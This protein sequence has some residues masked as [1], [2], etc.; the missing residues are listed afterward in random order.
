[1]VPEPKRTSDLKRSTLIVLLISWA[2]IGAYVFAEWLFQA[3]KPSYMSG[4]T[5]PAKLSVLIYTIS[6]LSVLAAILCGMILL[7]GMILRKVQAFLADAMVLIPALTLT[8]FALVLFDNF[9]YTIFRFGIVDSTGVFRLIYAAGFL[10]LCAYFFRRL[11][12]QI[13]KISG[14]PQM[15]P[16]RS[17]R[18]LLP[19]L[20]VLSGISFYVPLSYRND[21]DPSVY[22]FSGKGA[23][24][25]I[26]LISAEGIN[27]SHTSVYGYRR[28]TT[29]Y[30]KQLAEES[31]VSENH[32]TNSG[33]TSGSIISM[34]TS[35]TPFNT[36]VLFRPDILFNEDS[37]QHLPGILRSNGYYTAQMSFS[38]FADAYS[39]NLRD[40]FDEANGVMEKKS[41]VQEWINDFLP[42]N[43]SYFIYETGNR[44][45]DRLRHIFFLKTMV[46]AYEQVAGKPGYLNDKGE[47]KRLK[48]LLNRVDQPLFVQLHWMG[49]HG[50]A[51][52][53]ET[54]QFSAGKDI[55]QQSPW[56]DDFYDDGV[57]EFDNF[58]ARLY[59]ELE[60][61]G[62]ADNSVIIITSDHGQQWRTDRRI[63]LLIH[64]PGGEHARR[65]AT[66]TQNIDIAPTLLDVLNISIPR[67]MEGS[68]LLQNV[69]PN[70]IIISASAVE[71]DEA[72]KDLNSELK[73]PPFFQFGWISGIT[74]GS[75]YTIDLNTGIRSVIEI[76]DWKGDCG[77]S[78]D[79]TDVFERMLVYLSSHGFDVS[80]LEDI[81]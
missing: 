40:G 21:Q 48:E 74:C 79:G 76:P 67:W 34:L 54:R 75:G 10:I 64:F 15:V 31:L 29:P 56:D 30:L 8:C 20:L 32:F 77:P 33:S 41:V 14:N 62:M 69:D 22:S 27:A 45:S 3:T 50:P 71:L 7:A 81:K 59:A 24:P 49:T 57:L 38:Y 17:V 80:S 5:F 12:Q 73:T 4:I 19:I 36:R 26:F 25:N 66:S 53:P 78:Q 9:T 23:K 52:Y 16:Y 65:I 47:L 28:D 55:D 68:S 51:F 37:Y 18:F 70:R 11:T 58:I 43:Y 60:K 46:N 44:L 39:L 42:T 13:R 63:P 1:M 72:A 35:K 6:L 61:R 2:A